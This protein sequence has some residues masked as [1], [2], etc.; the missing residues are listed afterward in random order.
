MVAGLLVFSQT[1][2]LKVIMTERDEGALSVVKS[3]PC[4]PGATTDVCVIEVCFSSSAWNVFNV[5][6]KHC[7]KEPHIQ[8]AREIDCDRLYLGLFSLSP[9]PYNVQTKVALEEED[10]PDPTEAS[11]ERPRA[12]GFEETGSLCPEVPKSVTSIRG[13]PK[14]K[15]KLQSTTRVHG[16]S[17]MLYDA[18]SGL[19]RA[20]LNFVLNDSARV[21]NISNLLD[22]NEISDLWAGLLAAI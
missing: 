4:I 9:L 7:S 14:R 13:A 18:A 10:K 17:S 1:S 2:L 3:I 20:T 21:G 8:N 19:A 22:E 15:H 6:S 12:R 11:L 5:S 16:R